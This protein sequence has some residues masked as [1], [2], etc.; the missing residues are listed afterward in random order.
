MRDPNPPMYENPL[1]FATNPPR[2]VAC[3]V[4]LPTDGK[5]V[6]LV[7]PTGCKHDLHGWLGT[8]MPGLYSLGESHVANF[9]ALITFWEKDPLP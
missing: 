1:T 8:T 6:E 3:L 7:P 4:C 9:P 2:F 5:P